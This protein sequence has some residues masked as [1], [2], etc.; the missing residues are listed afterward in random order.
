MSSPVVQLLAKRVDVLQTSPKRLRRLDSPPVGGGRTIHLKGGSQERTIIHDLQYRTPAIRPS[1]WKSDVQHHYMMRSS[2]HGSDVLYELPMVEEII[3]NNQKE[4]EQQQQQ[5]AQEESVNIVQ[6]NNNNNGMKNTSRRRGR[7]GLLIHW[8]EKHQRLPN[9]DESLNTSNSSEE[10]RTEYVMG[11]RMLGIFRGGS[12]DAATFMEIKRLVVLFSATNTNTNMLQYL[13]CCDNKMEHPISD[14]MGVLYG[15]AEEESVANQQQ[16]LT[17]RTTEQS[18]QKLQLQQQEPL[19]E[20]EQEVDMEVQEANH[21]LFEKDME[22]QY[23]SDAISGL[24][25][26]N[27]TSFASARHNSLSRQIQRYKN[28]RNNDN[29]KSTRTLRHHTRI[30]NNNQNKQSAKPKGLLTLVQF[31]R[32]NGRTPKKEERHLFIVYNNVRSGRYLTY[33][34]EMSELIHMLGKERVFCPRVQAIYEDEAASQQFIEKHAQSKK[35]AKQKKQFSAF[36]NDDYHDNKDEESDEE[37]DDEPSDDLYFLRVQQ[38][39]DEKKKKTDCI[40]L[41]YQAI[42]QKSGKQPPRKRSRFLET[43]TTTKTTTK[44]HLSTESF[45]MTMMERHPEMLSS[46]SQYMTLNPQGA[47]VFDDEAILQI[48]D[49]DPSQSDDYYELD[50]F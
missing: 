2:D 40:S 7:L 50:V 1:D 6:H 19:Q 45:A 47:L 13:S 33:P 43:S 48:T 25:S 24:L 31:V 20:K 39:E 32:V 38:Q 29:N 14:R 4:E 49:S 41:L 21:V 44:K 42:E 8:I 36:T 35:M 5:Q 18:E 37:D 16:E 15:D 9:N 10:D 3:Q 17:T 30:N 34:D 28:K 12:C 22:M 26:L 23:D 11:N 27:G 46:L